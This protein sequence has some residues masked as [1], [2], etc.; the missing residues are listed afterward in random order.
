MWISRYLRS[1]RKPRSLFGAYHK[2]VH[3]TP[4][5]FRLWPSQCH[6]FSRNSWESCSSWRR[7]STS[8][9]CRQWRNAGNCAVHTTRAHDNHTAEQKLAGENRMMQHMPPQER[10]ENRGVEHKVGLLL[11]VET[12]SI[13]TKSSMGSEESEDNDESCLSERIEPGE[14]PEKRRATEGTGGDAAQ[15]RAQERYRTSVHR[16]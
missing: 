15:Q 4:R 8:H 1:S 10:V 5:M 16:S 11:G 3:K 14:S 6:K 13:T 2:S 7:Q 12:L 9:S